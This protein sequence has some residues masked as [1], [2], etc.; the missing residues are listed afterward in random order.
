MDPKLATPVIASPRVQQLLQRLH[1]LSAAE[2]KS[3][4]QRLFYFTRLVRF[5]ISGE[6]WSAAAEAHM[7][8]K[9]VA[10]D[11]EKCHFIYLLARSTGARHVIE[12]GTS[13]GVSTMYLAL[14]VGQDA[15]Q[16]MMQAKTTTLAG[17]VI[18]TEKEQTKAAK[19]RENWKEAGREVEQWMNSARETCWRH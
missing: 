7:C 14:A 1:A 15:L 4:S 6:T 9:F 17:K 19:A 3:W 11:A 16:Q 13:F 10:L 2:E 5:F 12:A 18:A 8:D